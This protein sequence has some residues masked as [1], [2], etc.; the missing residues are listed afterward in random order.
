[1]MDK[2]LRKKKIGILSLYYNN[3]NYGG[4][5]QA[6]ALCRVLNNKGYD[7]EQ[8]CIQRVFHPLPHKRT[9]KDYLNPKKYYQKL[10]IV[11]GPRLEAARLRTIAGNLDVR[12]K[13]VCKFRE[14]VPHSACVYTDDTILDCLNHYDV[15]ITGS[16][17]VWGITQW[18]SPYLMNFVPEGKVKLSYAASMGYTRIDETS[19]KIYA[20]T[21]KS[22]KAIS[23]REED[24]VDMLSPLTSVPVVQCLDPTLLLSKSEWDDITTKRKI[25]ERYIVCYFLGDDKSLRKLIKQYADNKNLKI[26]TF[27]HCPAKYHRSD[28]GFGDYCIYDAGPEEFV[29]YIKYA[30][31]VFTDS[32]HGSVFALIYKKRFLVF[33]RR[34][35]E[36]MVSRIYSLME[37]FGTRERFVGNPSKLNMSDI[38]MILERD[39]KVNKDNVYN[40]IEYS[41]KYLYTNL[42]IDNIYNI[43]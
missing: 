14:L 30:D 20:D 36:R 7:A 11:F 29:S 15:F 25:M 40:H 19:K 6:Y 27:P 34:G 13:K 33:N 23:V 8:I 17:Q 43:M 4:V 12:E 3:L 22:Y 16:D 39:V 28:V 5:L 2:P 18:T 35:E 1:M 10:K 24:A 41:K 37:I 38:S 9:I 31:Y 32:F 26:V 42:E 21:L